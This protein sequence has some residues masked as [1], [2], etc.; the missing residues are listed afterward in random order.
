MFDKVL[1]IPSVV[2]VVLYQWP[3]DVGQLLYYSICDSTSA[4]NSGPEGGTIF[5]DF[6]GSINLGVAH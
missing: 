3:D 5:M 1:G 2:G 6:W 4:G